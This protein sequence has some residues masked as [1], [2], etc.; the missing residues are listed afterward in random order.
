[1]ALT[2]DAQEAEIT[3]WAPSA[4]N[5]I[6]ASRP[7]VLCDSM[8]QVTSNVAP[9]HPKVGVWQR[10]DLWPNESPKMETLCARQLIAQRKTEVMAEPALTRTL[11]GA[12]D[13]NGAT[14]VDAAAHLRHGHGACPAQRQRK[15]MT[16]ESPHV[17]RIHVMTPQVA[18]SSSRHGPI[19][20]TPP[21]AEKD[22]EP[23]LRRGEA[24]VN[25]RR[26][27]PLHNMTS[28]RP[29]SAR[30]PRRRSGASQR[31]P[32]TAPD[33]TK[34]A[35]RGEAR[36]YTS[37]RSTRSPTPSGEDHNTFV[38]VHDDACNAT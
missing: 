23:R 2:R 26:V 14:S 24:C 25:S 18:L 36:V 27:P 16:M 11:G 30:R 3:N 31:A 6:A 17:R 38:E 33:L 34:K 1:M 29:T 15:Q 20:S 35:M 19:E 8:K 12:A 7:H 13:P 28:A 10:L 5:A 21:S 32:R 37:G 22:S 9:A 4:K